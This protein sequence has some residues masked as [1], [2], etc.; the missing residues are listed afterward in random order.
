MG[1]PTGEGPTL[2]RVGRNSERLSPAASSFRG[3]PPD[4]VGL[5]DWPRG[6]RGTPRRDQPRPSG[7]EFSRS[8][9]FNIGIA[10]SGKAPEGFLVTTSEGVRARIASDEALAQK[11]GLAETGM[12]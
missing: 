6:L 3:A 10:K 4:S 2:L 7:V 5:P 11:S 8:H 9:R 1:E 12:W